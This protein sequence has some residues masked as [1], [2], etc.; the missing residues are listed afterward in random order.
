MKSYRIGCA[1]P[2]A[3]LSGRPKSED[4]LALEALFG[5][6]EA[7]LAAVAAQGADTVELRA[8]GDQHS[9]DAVMRAAARCR[10]AGLGITIHGTL[11]ENVPPEEFF[12][13]YRTMFASDMQAEYNI[14]LHSLHPRAVS[15]AALAALCAEADRQ[16]Y[17]V[18]FTLE[19]N[20]RKGGV[21]RCCDNTA[22][23]AALAAALAHPRLSVCWDFGHFFYNLHH[24]ADTTD[25]L[26]PE[27]F[28]SRAAHTHIHGLLNDTTHFPFPQSELPL[29]AYC[30]SSG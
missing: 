10:G 27:E 21:I 19:N 16:N 4:Q 28:L 23:T 22:E 1:L 12:A 25:A 17:P 6:T 14:T 18:H 2:F 29:K 26:P 5:S 15:E 9:A 7:L 11:R 24:F 13:P 20:R 30:L 3:L 8:V